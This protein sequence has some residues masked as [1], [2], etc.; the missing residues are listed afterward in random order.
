LNVL[1]IFTVLVSFIFPTYNVG[2]QISIQDQ[3][4]TSETCYPGNGYSNGESF[5]LA[6]W[7]GDLNGGDYNVIFLSLEASW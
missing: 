7:N 1:L 4:V 3:N 6:D 2:Q 5:K